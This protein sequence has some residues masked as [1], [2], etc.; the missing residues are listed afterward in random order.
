MESSVNSFSPDIV[1]AAYSWA[2]LPM[3]HHIM[4]MIQVF[5]GSLIRAIG[6]IEEALWQLIQASR[7]VGETQLE[8]KLDEVVSYL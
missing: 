4:E 7:S 2:R 8:A 5:E 1:E 6:R 3:F